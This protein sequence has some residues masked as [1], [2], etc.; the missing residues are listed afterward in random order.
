MLMA[1]YM[2]IYKNVVCVDFDFVEIKRK[3]QAEKWMLHRCKNVKSTMLKLH[4][5][6]VQLLSQI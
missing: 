2:S 6:G 5:H 1:D 3:I 4:G